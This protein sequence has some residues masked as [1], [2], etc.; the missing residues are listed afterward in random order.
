MASWSESYVKVKQTWVHILA[1][2]SVGY[3][4]DSW[5]SALTSGSL[6]F[7]V[8]NMEMVNPLQRIIKKIE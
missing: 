1:L 7:P 6:C 2:L 5:A 3:L 8:C 4:L